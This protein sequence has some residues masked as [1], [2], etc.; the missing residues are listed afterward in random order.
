MAATKSKKMKCTMEGCTKKHMQILSA[1]QNFGESR[2]LMCAS[3]RWR[4]GAGAKS[5]SSERSIP[6]E[7]I[8]PQDARMTFLHRLIETRTS[9]GR[10]P[11]PTHPAAPG[12]DCS[13][14]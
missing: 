1:F 5:S 13:L 2:L 10:F 4:V 7:E 6:Y 3:C 11:P 14:L 8:Q 9:P 12:S